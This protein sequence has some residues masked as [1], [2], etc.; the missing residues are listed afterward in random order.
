MSLN[1]WHIPTSEEETIDVYFEEVGELLEHIDDCMKA[2]T[3][4]P[5]DKKTLTEIRRAF[6][7][8]KGSG[9]MANVLDLSEFAWKVENMLNQAIA[10]AVPVSQPMMKLVATVR[11]QIPSMID[12]FKNGRSIARNGD[13]V[14]LM[15]LADTLATEKNPTQLAAPLAANTT[16]VQQQSELY[17]F[18]VKLEHCMQRANEALRRSEMALHQVRL[19][20]TLSDDQQSVVKKRNHT[21]WENRRFGWTALIVSAVFGGVIAIGVVISILSFV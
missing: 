21:A 2:W 12:A 11:T 14:R 18:N 15:K 13:I 5:G 17:Q 6:H 7:T 3:K 19:I 16:G 20:S 4:L 9:R 10:G 8:I 1:C